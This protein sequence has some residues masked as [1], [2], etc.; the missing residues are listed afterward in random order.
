MSEQTAA[1]MARM[2]K[3]VVDYGTGSSARFSPAYATAGKTG[4]TD[5]DVDRWFVG[6]TPYYVAAVWV[7]C[8]TPRSMPFFSGNPCIPV[9]KNVMRQIHEQ[10][11][12]PSKSFAPASGTVTASYCIQS[13][14]RPGEGCTSI[15]ASVFK[16]GTQPFSVCQMHQEE[17]ESGGEENSG[18]ETDGQGENATEAED[19]AA[20]VT[21]SSGEASP[22]KPV[23]TPTP[24]PPVDLGE[25]NV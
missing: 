21:E 23:S 3:G 17:T 14:L 20:S 13:G 6:F 16:S 8:D 12:L 5:K 7:G 22:K 9:W 24:S 15:R 25:P 2:L 11:K 1:I 19:A 10:K 4:T 18:P